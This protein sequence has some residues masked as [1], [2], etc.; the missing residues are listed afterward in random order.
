MSKSTCDPMMDI[1][2]NL[3]CSNYE[4][5][6]R[7]SCEKYKPTLMDR[8]QCDEAEAW[9]K[10]Q[11]KGAQEEACKN[12]TFGSGTGSWSYVYA[13]S[14]LPEAPA[15]NDGKSYPN[16]FNNDPDCIKKLKAA[17][18]DF[19]FLG[20]KVPSAGSG[21]GLTCMIQNAVQMNGSPSLKWP[22]RATISCDMAMAMVGFDKDVAAMGVT[23][24]TQL[25]VGMCRR[26]RTKNGTSKSIS[27]HGYGAAIDIMGYLRNGRRVTEFR[28]MVYSPETDEGRFQLKIRKMAHKNFNQTLSPLWHGYL[29]SIFHLHVEQHNQDGQ[30]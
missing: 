23:G 1:I 22:N 19:T 13:C 7:K 26:K 24:Y 12:V 6:L 16:T 5:S 27:A 8:K 10:K 2:N 17:G 20:E 9:A 3:D 29:G 18:A 30:N 14:Q 15:D 4:G 25:Q 21:K 11:K 28:D